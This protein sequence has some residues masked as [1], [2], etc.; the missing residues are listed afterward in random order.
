[1]SIQ[2]PPTYPI[3]GPIEVVLVIPPHKSVQTTLLSTCHSHIPANLISVH[4]A[5]EEAPC[6]QKA[7]PNL[8]LLHNIIIRNLAIKY[9]KFPSFICEQNLHFASGIRMISAT[10]SSIPSSTHSRVCNSVV[11]CPSSLRQSPP[12]TSSSRKQQ[13][14]C[15][16]LPKLHSSSPLKLRSPWDLR[17][18]LGL[19]FPGGR[20]GGAGSAVIGFSAL[21]NFLVS[22]ATPSVL[23]MASSDGGN[24]GGDEEKQPEDFRYY[25]IYASEDGTTHFKECRM[26]GFDLKAYASSPQYVRSDFG[27]E[28]TKIVFTELAPGLEQSLHSC[29]QV[30]FVITLSGSWYVCHWNYQPY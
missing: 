16:A 12:A 15:P 10:L 9:S 1:M 2:H 6:R 20:G 30:Q 17:L 27:G 22:A 8:S 21:A 5:A 13:S 25:Q 29:P 19:G 23:R 14:P 11:I 3:G 7:Y 28:P 24:K 4:L 26:H 18:P